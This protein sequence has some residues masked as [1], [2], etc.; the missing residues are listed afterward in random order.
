MLEEIYNAELV[1]K[2]THIF[3]HQPYGLSHLLKEKKVED[4]KI[5]SEVY[6]KNEGFT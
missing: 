2:Y 1:K 5:V 6:Q 3:C 4:L